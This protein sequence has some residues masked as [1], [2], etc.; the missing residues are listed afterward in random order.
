MGGFTV[1]LESMQAAAA[2]AGAVATGL[3]GAAQHGGDRLAATW[4]T[5]TGASAHAI[6]GYGAR[7]ISTATEYQQVE[8]AVSGT[9]GGR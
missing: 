7:L 5:S 8:Q 3:R 1:D 4:T 6:D 2:A 9:L